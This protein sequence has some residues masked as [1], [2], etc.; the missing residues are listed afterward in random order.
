MT[1][2]PLINAFGSLAYIVLV[3]S[4]INFVSHIQKNKPDTFLAPVAFLSLFTL[5][6]AVMGYIFLYQPL[7]L[8]FDDKKKQAVNLFLQTLAAFAG[9]TFIVFVLVLSGILK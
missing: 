1:K 4:L 6:A 3:V 8:Y 7:Q 2:N 9:I 5:S